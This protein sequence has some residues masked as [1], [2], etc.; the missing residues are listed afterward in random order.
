M[1]LDHEIII[2][3]PNTTGV[4]SKT[5]VLISDSVQSTDAPLEQVHSF[6]LSVPA[7]A[8]S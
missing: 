7:Y 1:F 6:A 3:N 4:T 5:A 8:K 2:S